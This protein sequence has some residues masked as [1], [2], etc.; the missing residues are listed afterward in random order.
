MLQD[1]WSEREQIMAAVAGLDI[2]DD[3]GHSALMHKVYS[4]TDVAIA[5]TIPQTLEECLIHARLL[6]TIYCE[7]CDSMWAE[8]QDARLAKSLLAALERLSR[9]GAA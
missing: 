8:K 4:G 3:D 9:E 6:A 7:P 2:E 5:D 1:L